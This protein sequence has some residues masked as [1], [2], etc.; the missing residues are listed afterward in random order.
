MRINP[1]T[2]GIISSKNSLIELKKTN[3][4][5][6]QILDKRNGKKYQGNY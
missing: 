3:K 5:E 4:S 1:K 2:I 6:N